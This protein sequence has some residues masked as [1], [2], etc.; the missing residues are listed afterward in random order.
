MR[1]DRVLKCH[2]TLEDWQGCVLSLRWDNLPSP[3]SLHNV[4]AYFRLA[5]NAYIALHEVDK[6]RN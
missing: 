2:Q 3:V 5:H 6:K 4:A 1:F